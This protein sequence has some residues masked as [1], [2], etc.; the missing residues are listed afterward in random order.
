M[1][2]PLVE[3]VQRLAEPVRA[4]DILIILQPGIVGFLNQ[5]PSTAGPTRLLEFP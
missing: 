2:V 5:E 3:V 4:R 1:V